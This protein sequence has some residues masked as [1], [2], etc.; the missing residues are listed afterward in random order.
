M[1]SNVLLPLYTYHYI[2]KCWPIDNEGLLSG[3]PGNPASRDKSHCKPLGLEKKIK[4]VNVVA[5][6]RAVLHRHSA[7]QD[8]KSILQPLLIY[9]C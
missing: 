4:L 1:A 3:N 6:C 9:N 8:D 5:V 2:L 7:R